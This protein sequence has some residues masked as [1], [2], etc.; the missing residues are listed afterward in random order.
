MS[1]YTQDQLNALKEAQENA[2]D[3]LRNSD[4]FDKVFEEL[5]PKFDKNKDKTIGMGEYLEFI[6]AMFSAAGKKKNGFTC[7]YAL[8]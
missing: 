8:F 5:F 3:L 2:S 7:C 4:N 6:N 1:K